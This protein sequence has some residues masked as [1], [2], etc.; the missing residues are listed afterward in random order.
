MDFKRNIIDGHKI[1]EFFGQG[2]R[3]DHRFAGRPFNG[4]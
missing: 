1:A 4:M 3:L 2:F